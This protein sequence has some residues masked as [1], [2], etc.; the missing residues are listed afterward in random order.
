MSWRILA[1][2]ALAA[3]SAHAQET[4]PYEVQPG[5]SLYVIAGRLLEDSRQWP[6]V[7]RLNRLTRPFRLQPRQR[8]LLPAGLMKGAVAPARVEYV[9]G[10]V[11]ADGAPLRIGE[12]VGEGVALD[13]GAQG[14]V[15]LRLH[16]G[17]LLQLQ[18]NS[19]TKVLRLRD[20]P[21]AQRRNTLIELNQGRVDATVAPQSPGSRFQVKTPLATAGV[22]GTRFGVAVGAQAERTVADVIEGAVEVQALAREGGLPVAVQAGQGAVVRPGGPP[23]RK[24]LLPAPGLPAE[25]LRVEAN[26]GLLPLPTVPGAERYRVEVADDAAFT[27][28]LWSAEAPLPLV[29]DGLLDGRYR[30]RARAMDG[31]G[32]LGAEGAGLLWVKT[33]PV[34]PLARA[35]LPGATVGP[36]GVAITC[37]EVQQAQGYLLQLAGNPRFEPLLQEQRGSGRCQFELPALPVGEVYWRVAS[38]APEGDGRLERGPFSDP[39]RFVVVPLPPAPQADAITVDGGQVH[40][41]PLDGYRYRVQVATDT[42]FAA[43]VQ[44]QEVQAGSVTLAAPP[45]CAPYALRLQAIDAHGRRSPFSPPRLVHTDAS[46]CSSDGSPV[47]QAGGERVQTAR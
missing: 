15:S 22:R 29:L 39:G 19:R 1:A 12:L 47:Q 32:L 10:P 46:V 33:T 7:A 4:V 25:P 3:G 16:D 41:Q 42:G 2:A 31:D 24:A 44:D 45:R 9:R 5:E 30:L 17:S 37:T 6:E 13:V 18:A 23:L 14:F 8:L 38:L 27:R 11:N 28:V 35:P 40:W 20:L 21:A 43:L 36:Q 34:P 26:P